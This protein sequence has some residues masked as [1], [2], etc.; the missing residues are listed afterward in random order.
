M[1]G[2]A[3]DQSGGIIGSATLHNEFRGHPDFDGHTKVVSCTCD[4]SGRPGQCSIKTKNLIWP[5][6]VELGLLNSFT[7]L[8]LPLFSKLTHLS[9]R[10]YGRN[11]VPVAKQLIEQNISS[12][13]NFIGRCRA[14]QHLD[15][16][17]ATSSQIFH[18]LAESGIHYPNLGSVDTWNIVPE[19]WSTFI[20]ALIRAPKLKTVKATHDMSKDLPLGQS[21]DYTLHQHTEEQHI[22]KTR[23]FWEGMV[24]GVRHFGGVVGQLFVFGT[25]DR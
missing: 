10:D 3:K 11:P 1:H 14:L 8:D 2:F 6:D 9:F 21:A 4:Q 18:R 22:K 7:P 24:S 15:L 23:E 19:V 13:A 25:N 5:V 12:T 17:L 20:I 16:Q